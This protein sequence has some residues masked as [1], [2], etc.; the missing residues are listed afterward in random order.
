MFQCSHSARCFGQEKDIAAQEQEHYAAQVRQFLNFLDH[1]RQSSFWDQI[2]KQHPQHQAE[3]EALTLLCNS[4][5]V[6]QV[7]TTESFF[8]DV[9]AARLT[10]R[11]KDHLSHSLT[12]KLFNLFPM[13]L[14]LQSRLDTLLESW[15]VTKSLVL[16]V[17]SAEQLAQTLAVP[18]VD[19][20]LVKKGD[21]DYELH[22]PAQAGVFFNKS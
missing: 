14:W 6:Q 5:C 2:L 7:P 21:S 11:N 12:Y 15:T 19:N 22:V 3:V 20:V 10:L 17:Q 4:A 16:D 9:E 13:G 1:L 8:A 18:T